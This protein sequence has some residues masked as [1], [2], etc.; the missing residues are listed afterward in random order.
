MSSETPVEI[1]TDGACSGNPGPGGW[2]ALLRSGAHEKLIAGAEAAT[3]NNRMELTAAIRALEALTRRCDVVLWTDSEY[4]RRGISEWLARWKASG[5]RTAAKQPVANR[6]L[7]EE[8]DRLSQRHRIDWRWVKGHSGHP[9]NDRV[10][11]A[12]RAAIATLQGKRNDR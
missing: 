6:E 1:H 10:D 8:L 12:A 5:W 7:W 2:A 9:E 3:T 11:A 4:V